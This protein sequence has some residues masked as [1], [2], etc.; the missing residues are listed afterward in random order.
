MWLV[1]GLCSLLGFSRRR[2]GEPI[3]DAHPVSLDTAL[4]TE[5]ALQPVCSSAVQDCAVA[6]A[7]QGFKKGVFQPLPGDEPRI[8][9]KQKTFPALSHTPSSSSLQSH[10]STVRSHYLLKTP[11]DSKPVVVK[12]G[13]SGIN[14]VRGSGNL[15]ASGGEHPQQWRSSKGCRKPKIWIENGTRGQFCWPWISALADSGN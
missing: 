11:L 3:G 14:W 1:F 4:D 2:S 6:V 7:L 13:S 5:Q 8:F 15:S 10:T 9:H 12:H